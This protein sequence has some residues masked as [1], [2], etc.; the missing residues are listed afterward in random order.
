MC[1]LHN[2]V[3]LSRDPSELGL[4]SNSEKDQG[5]GYRP[6][7]VPSNPKLVVLTC[8]PLFKRCPPPGHRRQ[9]CRAWD[10]PTPRPIND[11]ASPAEMGLRGGMLRRLVDVLPGD[12]RVDVEPRDRSRRAHKKRR[13]GMVVEVE[14]T[15]Y[16]EMFLGW[17][18]SSN[19]ACRCQMN[20]PRP[21]TER[22]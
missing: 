12:P 17:R 8:W 11:E 2:S 6:P 14:H 10:S 7:Q 18:A 1:S 13:G 22:S 15:M 21:T 3:G 5:E 9:R 16:T 20:V 4:P 19:G